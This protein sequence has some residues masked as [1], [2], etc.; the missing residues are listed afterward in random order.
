VRKDCVLTALV[1]GTGL[2]TVVGLEVAKIGNGRHHTS[3]CDRDSQQMLL[4]TGEEA[5]IYPV[6]VVDV[7][8][9]KCRALLDTRPE[10]LMPQQLLSSDWENNSQR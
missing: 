2:W 6:V 8:G 7:G 1:Q 10:V 9:I 5:V 4:A 3:I